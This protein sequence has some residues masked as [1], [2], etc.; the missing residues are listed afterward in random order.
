MITG[1]VPGGKC[2]QGLRPDLAMVTDT[3]LTPDGKMDTLNKKAKAKQG[4]Q[5]KHQERN[6]TWLGTIH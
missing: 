2:T 4:K 3:V 5:N 6:S 1:T